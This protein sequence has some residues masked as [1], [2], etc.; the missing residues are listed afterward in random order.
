[1]YCHCL[2]IT[3]KKH[4]REIRTGVLHYTF[5]KL[6]SSSHKGRSLPCSGRSRIVL[7]MSQLP[8]DD[9]LINRMSIRETH[10]VK[11]VNI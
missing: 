6:I 8:K 9:S 2:E 1:M 4:K 5:R 7:K 10:F 11:S 3:V